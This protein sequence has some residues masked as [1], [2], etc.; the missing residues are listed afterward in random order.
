MQNATMMKLP[1]GKRIALSLFTQYRNVQAAIHELTYLFWECTLRCNLKCL[2]CG[3][4]CQAHSSVPD[5]PVADFLNVLDQVK[6]HQDPKKVTI[7]LTGGEP[8]LRN[9][10]ET[11]GKEFQKRGYAWGMVTNGY[12]LDGE[13]FKRLLAAGLRSMTVSL[14]GL[15]KSHDWLRSRNG[16]FPRALA[17]IKLAASVPGLIY[18]VVT[19]VNQKNIGELEE[20]RK[21]LIDNGVTRWRLFTIF[22]KGRAADEPLLDIDGSQLRKLM[23]FIVAARIEGRIKAS[24]SCEGFLGPYEA[25]VRDGFF[26][27]RA[28]I[29]VG[30]VLIDGSIS[31]CPSL[32]G[33][34]I[35]GNIY[36]DSFMDV[37]N[38]RFQVMRKRKWLRNGECA[39]CKVFKWCD[40]NGLHLR[41]E[42]TGRILRC[43]YNM[44]Q[45]VSGVCV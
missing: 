43:H 29:N 20:L 7:A 11:C 16:S 10:L 26:F 22:P 1:L 45:N 12:A 6:E 42:K 3:S 18:D 23:D 28:G 41:D 36:R 40:G 31:A 44:L 34:Y 38:N 13:R 15:E 14:D 2:H 17:S 37:W 21:L 25:Q 8:L 32:R 19:C 5:M 9:D 27:C 4:D 24:F 30:S 33:D 39:D 35:Q